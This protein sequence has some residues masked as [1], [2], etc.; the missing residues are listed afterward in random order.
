MCLGCQH[1]GHKLED[2]NHFV[3]YIVAKGL[4]QR[5]PQLI[6]QIANLHKQDRSRLASTGIFGCPLTGTSSNISLMH[7]I[8]EDEALHNVRE[9]QRR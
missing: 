5:H 2:C 9:Y 7:R 4:A 6:M 1:P 3:D 8:L